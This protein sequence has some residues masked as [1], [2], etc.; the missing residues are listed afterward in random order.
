MNVL[1]TGAFGNVGRYTVAELLRQGYTVRAFDLPT[2]ANRKTARRFEARA[3]IIW[4]DIRDAEAVHRAAAGQD[5][6]LHL[7]AIIPPMSDEDPELARQVNVDGTRHVIAACQAQP[8]PP[9]LFFASTFDLFGPTLHLAPPRRADDPIHPTDP[10]THHKAEGEQLVRESGLRWLIFRFSDMPL[11]ALR[12]AHP[13]MYEIG[14]NT[15]FE[16]M[17]PAD[18]ALAVVNAIKIPELWTGRL[19]LVGGG[20]SCQITYRDFIFGMLEAMGIGALPEEA[21]TDKPYVTDWLDTEE[22]QRLLRYQRHSFDDIRHEIADL[23]G[24]RRFIM[25]LVRPLVRRQMLALS[26]YYHQGQPQA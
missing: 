4:G 17:H 10:Y 3:E 11:I 18:G 14:L 15:R 25:P 19:L 6:V 26:P 2:P 16:T 7:A 13:I 21:F 12:E 23:L 20:P 9:R 8:T 24:W 5:V 22:S 1:V